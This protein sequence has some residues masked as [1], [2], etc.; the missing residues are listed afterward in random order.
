LQHKL[1]SCWFHCSHLF[2]QNLY[3][4]LSI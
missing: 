3:L 1:P 2:F 4:I